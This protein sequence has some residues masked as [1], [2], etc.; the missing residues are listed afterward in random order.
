MTLAAYMSESGKTDAEIAAAL[1]VNAEVVRLWRHGRRRISAERAIALSKLTGIPRHELRPDLWEAP[2]TVAPEP[3]LKSA[4]ATPVPKRRA[5]R[6][7]T[8]NPP[9]ASEPAS[10]H[11]DEAA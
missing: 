7:S 10:A 6:T 2:D 11:R 4:E 1:G 8:S 5:R 3:E 9:S